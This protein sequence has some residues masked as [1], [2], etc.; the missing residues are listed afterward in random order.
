MLCGRDWL[1][2]WIGNGFIPHWVLVPKVSSSVRTFG[3]TIWL[4][5]CAL[6]WS[7]HVCKMCYLLLH[8]PWCWMLSVQWLAL[9][10]CMYNVLGPNPGL[11]PILPAFSW[12]DHSLASRTGC[13]TS[14]FVFFSVSRYAG[15]L[16]QIR[17]WLVPS[18]FF[19][20]H[21]WLIIWCLMLV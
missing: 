13:M 1:D 3:M 18:P 10:L 6:R 17:C 16:L 7:V 4:Q 2:S 8:I 5:N 20:V 19:P 12:W 9:L 14:F 15:I 11:S 21:N